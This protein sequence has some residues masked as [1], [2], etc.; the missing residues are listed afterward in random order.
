MR[1]DLRPY[2]EMRDSGVELL[3]RVPEHWAVRRLKY[4]VSFSGGGTPSKTNASFW[5]GQI[6]WVSPKDMTRKRI[7]DTADHITEDAVAASAA[8]IVAAGA[9]LVVVRSGILRRTI[10]VAINTVPMAINQDM[11]AMLPRKGIRSE[12]LHG[13][14]QG[15]QSFWLSEWTKQGATVESIEHRLLADSRIPIPPLSE[16]RAIAR[17]LD[18]ADRRI[19]RYIRAKERLIELLEEERRA[20]IHEAVTG[21]IDVRTGQPYPAYKDSGVEWLGEVPEHWEVRRL[22]TLCDMRS[23]DTITAMSIDEVGKY[24]VFGGNGIRGYSSEYTH[25]GDYV[26]IGRQGA[27]C[28]NVHIARGRF[29]A[30]EHA[31][32]ATLHCGHVLDW[33]G[34]ALETMNLNQYSI[35]AAQP[36]LS[37]DRVLHLWVPV[38]LAHEQGAIARFLTAAG[39]RLSA[40]RVSLARQIALL[41]EYR[42][43]LIADVVTG[44]LDVR[45]AAAD[46]PETIPLA[47]DRDRPDVI[48][49]EPN[50]HST[51]RD[52]M[53]EAIP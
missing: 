15:N 9:V 3:G 30:S 48:P 19:R 49:T 23:G 11:K 51:E 1:A 37:V 6:P 2:P 13:L 42:T 28:G 52:V 29:W 17:F 27:L 41:R 18:D 5:K 24:R 50:L 33:F 12:Y 31:V 22:K 38:P 44:K 25:D 26:L 21:R 39:R 43:R 8:K 16:Q 7:S 14:I 45:E 46:L 40:R 20:T 47:A 10:P 36:G 35:A 4:A 34:A 32:V 53:K